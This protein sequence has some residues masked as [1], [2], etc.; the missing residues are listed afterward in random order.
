MPFGTRKNRRN[1]Y[2]RKRS[3]KVTTLQAKT[4]TSAKSQAN[5]IVK[6][7][8]QLTYV[9]KNV[10]DNRK[11]AQYELNAGGATLENGKWRI[12]SLVDPS[13]WAARFQANDEIANNTK[14]NLHSIDVQLYYRPT[15]S[16]IPLTA[17]LVTVYFLKLRKETALQTLEDSAQMTTAGWNQTPLD[18]HMK[19][20]YWNTQDIGLSYEALP[21]LNKGAFK[22]LGKRQFQVQNIIQNTAATSAGSE[23]APDVAVTTPQGTFKRCH[24]HIKVKNL[25][26]SGILSS[27]KSM[28]EGDIQPLDRYYIATHVGGNGNEETLEDG[29]TC[30]EGIHALITLRS[31]Q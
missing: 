1:H 26:K 20:K 11:W 8:K 29:N 18:D 15:D 2:T 12:T 21:T 7:Q 28:G 22:V 6:L 16:V 10:K 9:K 27:W 13:Q 4:N 3:R 17:K 19:N 23:L 24:F 31:T 14:V 5:Q 30:S 25:I